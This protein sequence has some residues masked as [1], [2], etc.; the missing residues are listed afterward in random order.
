MKPAVLQAYRIDRADGLTAT[1]GFEKL[2]ILVLKGHDG[3]ERAF[4]ISRADAH[5]IGGLLQ[6]AA[7]EVQT[8]VNKS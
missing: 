2:V 7:L 1:G 6:S 5:I 8:E 4:A 3:P